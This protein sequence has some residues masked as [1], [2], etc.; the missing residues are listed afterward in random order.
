MSDNNEPKPLRLKY[1]KRTKGGIVKATGKKA[2]VN[3][4]SVHGAEESL[5]LFKEIRGEYYSEDPKS[6]VPLY[7]SRDILGDVA[8]LHFTQEDEFGERYVYA[9]DGL[10]LLEVDNIQQM[11]L[12]TGDEYLAKSASDEKLKRLLGTSTTTTQ[13]APSSSQPKIV[14]EEEIVL[15]KEEPAKTTKAKKSAKIDDV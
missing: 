3:I 5:A 14:V 7:W 9:Q 10:G 13:S 1:I 12:K 8:S 15:P 6:K 2:I 11:A 4:Y